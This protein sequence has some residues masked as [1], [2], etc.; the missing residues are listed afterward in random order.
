[1]EMPHNEYHLKFCEPIEVWRNPDY[2][3]NLNQLPLPLASIGSMTEAKILVSFAI[4]SA[5]GC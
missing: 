4:P 2:V 5:G 3:F 1:M